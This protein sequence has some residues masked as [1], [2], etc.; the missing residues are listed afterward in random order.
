M[1]IRNAAVDAEDGAARLQGRKLETHDQ[2][3][4]W[5]AVVDNGI[6]ARQGDD[7]RDTESRDI[8]GGVAKSGVTTES[9]TAAGG[10]SQSCA[11]AGSAGRT[12]AASGYS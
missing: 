9:P 6:E 12:R 5:I 4:H 11:N 10:R 7:V 3:I 2:R 1:H 8:V